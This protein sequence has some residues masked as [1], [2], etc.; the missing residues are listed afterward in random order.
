MPTNEFFQGGLALMLMGAVIAA[1]RYLPV[2]AWHLIQRRWAISVTTRDKDLIRWIGAWL[3]DTEYGKR[4]Q[5]LDASAVY[6]SKGFNY[7]LWP[8]I[9]HHSFREA[10]TRFW[11]DHSLEDQGI[12]GKSDLLT[13][14]V[15]G[16]NPAPLRKAIARAVEMANTEGL[17]K[18]AVYINDRWGAWD[19]IRL[20]PARAKTSL[21]LRHGLMQEIL[22]DAKEFLG[23]VDWYHNRGLPHRR[24]YLLLG[25]AGNGKSTIVQVLAT[26]LK[27]PIY[28]LSLS[29]P[30]FTDRGLAWALGRTPDKCLV[31]IEDFEKIVLKD[32]ITPSGLL[33]A[34]DGPLASEGRLLII[35]ANNINSIS[36]H[37]LRPGRIDRQW[38]IDVPDRETTDRFYSHFGPDGA[39]DRREFIA[40][41]QRSNWS[42]ARIQQ[43][44]IVRMKSQ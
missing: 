22:I 21:F 42:M 26:E 28:L 37:F 3:S 34:I 39:V 16:R 41:A 20:F 18:N 32:A 9:G 1:I 40:E 29:E 10:G 35:T 14:R 5:W 11:L 44:L 17:D 23:G 38:L 19:R 4:C 33:N 7:M 43:E 12:A 30:E 31:V 13:I 2:F 15:L 8:G 36:D 6:G 24:G 25:P 27:L